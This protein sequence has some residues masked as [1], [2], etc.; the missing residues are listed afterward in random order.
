LKIGII[1]DPMD[2][3]SSVRVYLSNLIS[4]LVKIYD[5]NKIY[6]IHSR[7]SKNPLYW[8]CNE[9]IIPGF[10]DENAP[11]KMLFDLHRPFLMKKYDLDVIHY[12]HTYAPITFKA[13]ATKNVCL[14]TTIGSYTDPELYP[15]PS[16]ILI[17]L[18]RPVIAKMDAIITETSAEKKKI[19]RFLDIEDEKVKVI[20]SGIDEIYRPL[21]DL[22]EIAYELKNKYGVSP[23]FILH[24]STYRPT[25]NGPGIIKAFYWLKKYGLKHKLVWIGKPAQRFEEV[26]ELVE[27]LKLCSEVNF[28]GYIKRGDLPKFY[29]LADVFL[30]PSFRESFPHVLVEAL[31]CGCPV[32]T[33][34]VTAMPEIVGDAGILVNPYD[35]H[36]IAKGIYKVLSDESL[37]EELRRKGLERAKLFSW[38]KCAK[39]TL[40]VYREVVEQT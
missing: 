12:T 29:N 40:K 13:S 37:R 11:S 4:E 32:V 33:S 7:K 5:K 22:N 26:L 36:D 10:Y 15:L 16:R 30:L 39:E 38:E 3:A 14:I 1:T 25:K 23:P 6:L 21:S 28:L 35:F 20:P 9:L 19:L 17:R 8:H 18:A 27:K 34:N 2:T 31:A 24:V